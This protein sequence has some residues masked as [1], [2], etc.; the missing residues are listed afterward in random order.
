MLSSKE[1][2]RIMTPWYG[3][4][5]II[6]LIVQV[7]TR[8]THRVN[9]P[10]L[11]WTLSAAPYWRANNQSIVCHPDVDASPESESSE[12][13]VTDEASI[14]SAFSGRTPSSSAYVVV[15]D[16]YMIEFWSTGE[17]STPWEA[18]LKDRPRTARM[19]SWRSWRVGIFQ[20]T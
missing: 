7:L 16:R 13:N 3:C 18:I 5:A 2:T 17:G 14:Q 6:L 11:T 9:P 4:K 12:S 10:P 1:R 20:G 19:S 8:R 15:D